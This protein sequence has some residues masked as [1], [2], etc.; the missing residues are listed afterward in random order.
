MLQHLLGVISEK[1]GYDLDDLE[2]DMELEADL[3]I[4][5]VKQAEF[6]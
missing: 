4:D 3:G 5:T 1:T 6:R 2:A